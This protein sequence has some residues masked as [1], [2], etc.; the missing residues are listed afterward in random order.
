MRSTSRIGVIGLFLANIANMG[1]QA[2]SEPDKVAAASTA[3]ARASWPSPAT[4]ERAR[5]ERI[6]GPTYEPVKGDPPARSKPLAPEKAAV[7][8][9][10]RIAAWVPPKHVW[11]TDLSESNVAVGRGKFGKHGLLGDAP[12]PIKVSG[13]S[14]HHGLGLPPDGHVEYTLNRQYRALRTSVALGDSPVTASLAPV[15]FR[16]LGDGKLLWKSYPLRR[17]AVGEPCLLDISNIDVLRLEVEWAPNADGDKAAT[18]AAWVEP[19]VSDIAPSAEQLTWFAPERYEKLETIASELESLRDWYKSENFTELDKIADDWRKSNRRCGGMPLM[20]DYYRTLSNP[21]EQTDG[22]WTAQIARLERWQKAKPDS[23]TPLVL[24][25]ECY[26]NYAWFARGGN[27]ASDVAPEAWPKFEERL[28]KAKGSLEKARKFGNDPE[29]FAAL[30]T[31]ALG[32]SAETETVMELVETGCKMSPSYC[33]IYEA[34]A[35]CFLPQWG[36]SVQVEHKFAE[37]MREKLGGDL[38][39]EVYFRIA[40]VLES[41]GGGYYAPIAQGGFK[42]EELTPGMNVVLRDYPEDRRFFNPVCYFAYLRHDDTYSDSLFIG[43]DPARYWKAPW[44]N[45]SNLEQNRRSIRRES[46]SA[47]DLIYPGRTWIG[48]VALLDEPDRFIWSGESPELRTASLAGVASDADT[49]IPVPPNVGGVAVDSAGKNVIVRW[50]PK[51]KFSQLACVFRL[52][53]DERPIMLAGHTADIGG[54]AMNPDGKHCGTTAFDKTARL[55]KLPSAEARLLKHPRDPSCIAF[56][57]DGRVVATADTFGIVWLWDASTGDAKGEP[58][59]SVEA[60]HGQCR[61]RFLP[62]GKEL[63]WAARD[64]TIRRWNLASR[65]CTETNVAGDLIS[66]IDLSHDGRCLA[67]GREGGSIDL[68]STESWKVAHIADDH[69]DA[70]SGLAITPDNEKLLSSSL[71]GTIKVR[72]LYKLIPK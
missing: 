38:G 22:G 51:Q 52:G 9:A 31:V 63:I 14:S 34:A 1:C 10:A 72:S 26:V 70:V 37:L 54:I 8:P 19:F 69:F 28:E 2:S 55:W 58:L 40:N 25:G 11:L 18:H 6:G 3:D 67:V 60:D 29:A 48:N 4:R 12:G 27:V 57:P 15:L 39:D 53:E 66:Q 44:N 46:N 24:L 56:S 71:D 13:I 42:T 35:Y 33:P 59:G 43:L 20:F 17:T 47:R 16:V 5:R 41:N 23:V 65:T 7:K 64:G 50:M 61:L 30:L 62:D 21:A 68:V 32:Q 45:Y 49:R 36:G